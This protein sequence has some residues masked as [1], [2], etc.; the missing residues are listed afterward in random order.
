MA[1][2]QRIAI[3][4]TG[5]V[6]LVAAAVFADRGFRVLTSSQDAEKVNTINAGKSPF[7]ETGLDPVIARVVK[8]G[9]LRAVHGREEAVRESDICFIAVGTPSLMS[10]EA[11]LSLVKETAAAIGKALKKR[12]AY[13]LIVARST[14][15]PGTTRNIII[16]IVEKH[17]GK[18]AG[19]DFGVC[20]SP[21]FL[22]Q[23]AAL[24]DTSEPD[25]VVVGEF[26]KRSG[27]VL[28]KFANELYRGQKVPVLR[29]NL[30]SAEM[31]KYG[32]NTFLAMNISYINEMARIAE[33]IPGIDITEVVKGVGADW[34]I[35]PVFLN[36]GAGYGGSCFPK[37]VKA[38][39]S[40]A[41]LREVEPALLETVEEVN[42]QQASHVVGLL[43]KEL[44]ELKGRKIALLGLAFKPGTDDM[45]E[46][47]AVKVA[48]HLFA[49]HAQI[50]AYDPV[51][52]PNAKTKFIRDTIRIRYAESA[53]ECVKGADACV[54][55]TEWDE[56]RKLK[57][58]FFN[59]NMKKSVIIDARRIYDASFR[60]KVATYR[61][62]GLGPA[63][64]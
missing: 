22:R 43:R 13:S 56:F 54:I 36:A 26:D 60:S 49:E 50:V 58:G 40:F 64:G 8:K 28:Q 55:L 16:P 9:I 47:P 31:V 63:T 7:F 39:I 2:K 3:L 6:G 12:K 57:A 18:K 14:I 27:D 46:A 41:Q 17:S 35:N 25:S 34:R 61:G 23:G 20:M 51:A 37:D 45:R 33:T 59:K 5:Y 10:G 32:R 52:I 44:G 48:N 15:V 21:E 38:L 4:G 30:E 24:K 1:R 62:I 19:R 42:L 11:D 29:M 53:K